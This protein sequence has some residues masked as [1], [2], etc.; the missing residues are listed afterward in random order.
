LGTV[1]GSDG[2]GGYAPAGW[3][4]SFGAGGKDAYLFEAGPPDMPWDITGPVYLE[5]DGKCDMRDIGLVASHFGQTAPPAPLAC[6][7]TGP[8]YLEPDG[9]VDMRDV[10]LVAIHFGETAP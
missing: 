9:K 8:T 2:D 4:N 6:D 7:L 10:G 5:P 3:T 1:N